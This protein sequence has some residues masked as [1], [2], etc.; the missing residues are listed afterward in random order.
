VT[1][2]RLIPV[3]LK[4]IEQKNLTMEHPSEAY[5]GVSKA[6]RN[7]SLMYHYFPLKQQAS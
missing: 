7:V 2:N 6:L 3:S 5:K 1:V 4:T